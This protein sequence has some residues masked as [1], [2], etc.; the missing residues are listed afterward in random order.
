[1]LLEKEELAVYSEEITDLYQKELGE[2]TTGLTHFGIFS[3]SELQAV[4]SVKNYMGYWYLRGC[5]VKPE[6]R[7]NGFH[8]QLIQERLVYLSARTDLVRVSVYPDNVHSINNIKAEGFEFEKRKKLENG[9]IVFVY[10][11]KL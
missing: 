6:F 2:I 4:A 11:I 3:V 9:N 10:K 7:G 1:M 8:R 5:V